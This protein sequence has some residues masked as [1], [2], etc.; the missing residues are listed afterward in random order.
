MPFRNLIRDPFGVKFEIHDIDLAIV[1]AVRRCILTDIPVVAFQGEDE[2]SL[3]VLENNGPLHNEIILHRFG[4]IPIHFSEEETESFE[5]D[6]YVF[7]LHVENTTPAMLNVTTKDFKVTKNGREMVAKEVQRLFPAHPISKDHVLITRLRPGEVIH[8]RG[9]PVR[10][11]ARKHAGFAAAFCTLSFMN[12]PVAAAQATNV[13][14][15]ERSYIKNQYNDP[16]SFQFSIE[17]FN[18][19]TPQYLVTKSLEIL[20]SKLQKVI[21]ELYQEP[22]EYVKTRVWDGEKGHGYEFI[23]ENEDDTLGNLMQS[24]MY[25]HYIR[26]GKK[27]EHGRTVSFVGYVCPHPL[28]STMILR[29]VFSEEAPFSEYVEALAETSRRIVSDLQ[30]IETE[31]NRFAKE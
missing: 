7:E 20:R 17:P 13:L 10:A 11:T 27:T 26:E 4:L 31:W 24:L 28:E 6:D 8:V 18:G 12:D 1:N 5:V 14:D 22:S 21:T 30:A 23:F 15:K 19:F 29:L 16:T 9:K 25:N 2:A 3:E